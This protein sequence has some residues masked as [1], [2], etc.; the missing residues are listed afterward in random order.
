MWGVIYN[1][2]EE[3][4]ILLI[5]AVKES[6]I[7]NL[8]GPLNALQYRRMDFDEFCAATLSVHQLE[9]VDQWERHARCAY[10][11][12][13]KGRND[14]IIIEE[15]ALIRIYNGAAFAGDL[16]NLMCQFGATE[17]HDVAALV[18]GIAS[19]Q[20]IKIANLL[21]CTSWSGAGPGLMD[22]V[23]QGALQVIEGGCEAPIHTILLV[24]SYHN[25][26]ETV[27]SS[28]ASPH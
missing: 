14:S 8:L 11:H 22:D 6:H 20:V 15:L 16:I 24:F 9:A 27:G 25:M 18:G 2:S 17:L 28:M 1:S 13:K 19:Q 7:P 12:F 10:E 4:S 3:L 26:M 21:D 23:T 5:D